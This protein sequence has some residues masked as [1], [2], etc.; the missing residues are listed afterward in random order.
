[1]Q[2]VWLV[3]SSWVWVGLCDAKR[4]IS[5]V[6]QQAQEQLGCMPVKVFA[7]IGS[8]NPFWLLG[9]NHMPER[10][11][12]VCGEACKIQVYCLAKRFWVAVGEYLGEQLR[13]RGSTSGKAV[14]AWRRAAEW[15]H[16]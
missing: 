3:V 12:D 6:A 14:I 10:T 5:A 9:I 15:T 13:T 1:M 8:E 7:R 16:T 2:F 4:Q 11:I